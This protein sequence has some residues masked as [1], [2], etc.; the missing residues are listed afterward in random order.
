MISVPP[1][2]VRDMF[3]S[4]VPGYDW[5]NHIGSLG[6]DG[7][8]RREILRYTTGLTPILDLGTGTGD[9]AYELAKAEATVVGVDFSEHMLKRAQLKYKKQPGLSFHV[10]EANSLPFEAQTF[11]G[12]TSAFL[13]RNLYAEGVLLGTFKECFRV[14]RPG[15][16]MIHLELTRPLRRWLAWGHE[17]YLDAILPKIGRLFFQN[18]WPGGY[19]QNTIKQF[20]SPPEVCQNMR[21][22]GFEAISHTHLSGGM[23]GLFV[24]HKRSMN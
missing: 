4:L 15:G 21:W 12:V 19:L 6:L 11:A 23:A 18:R 7:R 5:F 24:A 17:W 1:H 3:N 8:W 20:I 16:R 10:A 22:A 9:V 2:H 13:L 14:L